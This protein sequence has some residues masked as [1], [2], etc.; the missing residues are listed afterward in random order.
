MTVV[1]VIQ[2]EV[3]H[4]SSLER[5][6]Q[7][8]LA[9]REEDVPVIDALALLIEDYEKKAFPIAAIDPIQAVLFR[10][11]QHHLTRAELAR[12]THIGRGHISEILQGTRRMSLSVI[13]AFH[14]ELQIPLEVLFRVE[15]GEQNDEEHQSVGQN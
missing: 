10:M 9:D 7:L 8:I 13:R 4:A 3:D 6:E 2:N 1:R 14:T 11:E 12:K 5:L 15:A